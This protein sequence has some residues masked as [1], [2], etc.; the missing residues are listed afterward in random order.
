[1][2]FLCDDIQWLQLHDNLTHY[3]QGCFSLLW[4]VVMWCVVMWCDV[5]WCVVMC[6]DVMW[7]D[8]L[9]CDVM[10]C[11]VLWCDVLWCDV[12]W[13]DVMWCEELPSSHG[14]TLYISVVQPSVIWC[15][16]FEEV[17][18]GIFP[19]W[20]GRGSIVVKTTVKSLLTFPSDNTLTVITRDLGRAWVHQS[21]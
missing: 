15:V 1:M 6:C 16:R 2:T 7:C 12:M 18:V 3:Y 20:A 13:C 4:C 17:F 9:W 10:W 21:L 8:V 11:V 14:P 19:G 5:L